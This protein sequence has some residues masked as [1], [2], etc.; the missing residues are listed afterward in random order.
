MRGYR[1]DDEQQDGDGQDEAP[2]VITFSGSVTVRP[3][4]VRSGE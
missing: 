4:G 1:V 3:A 2:P